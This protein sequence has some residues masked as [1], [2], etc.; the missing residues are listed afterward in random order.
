MDCLNKWVSIATVKLWDNI[1]LEVRNPR[2]AHEVGFMFLNTRVLNFTVREPGWPFLLWDENT[3]EVG[4]APGVIQWPY[5]GNARPLYIIWQQGSPTSSSFCFVVWQSGRKCRLLCK[6]GFHNL[7]L[8]A[9]L[10]GALSVRWRDARRV[11]PCCLTTGVHQC[12]AMC[13]HSEVRGWCPLFYTQFTSPDPI[14]TSYLLHCMVRATSHITHAKI[15]P[16][17]CI[18]HSRKY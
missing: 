15:W 3:G 9:T 6:N 7:G 10:V 11:P 5:I 4:G 18:N 14:P 17:K 16:R 12:P 1:P 13:G 8:I 2:R